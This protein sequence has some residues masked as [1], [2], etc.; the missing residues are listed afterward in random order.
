MPR[1]GQDRCT[2]QFHPQDQCTAPIHAR[3]VDRYSGYGDSEVVGS[4][5]LGVAFNLQEIGEDPQILKTRLSRLNVEAAGVT[6]E[7][8]AID[9]YSDSVTQQSLL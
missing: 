6:G 3:S 4:L 9:V 2:A 8:I 5:K 1:V 7:T